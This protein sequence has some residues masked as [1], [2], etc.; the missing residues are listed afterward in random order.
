MEL[1]LS[2]LLADRLLVT[3]ELNVRLLLP[4]R[5]GAT[6]DVAERL[7]DTVP[8]EVLVNEAEML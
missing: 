7:F 8:L 2:E 5:D 6:V 3:D 4:E 1:E